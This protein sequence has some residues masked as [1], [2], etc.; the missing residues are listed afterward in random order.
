MFKSLSEKKD[1]VKSL[2]RDRVLATNIKPFNI[3]NS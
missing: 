3:V 2:E 1:A